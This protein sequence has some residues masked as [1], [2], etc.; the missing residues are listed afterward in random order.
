MAVLFLL[1][2]TAY[3]V[4]Q[5]PYVTMPA[6]MTEDPAERGRVLG[7]RVGFLGVAILLS[8]ASAPRSPTPTATAR[9]ATG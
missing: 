3:A 9:R 4:F 5:V 6:E 2:A 8:G 1:A 7:R